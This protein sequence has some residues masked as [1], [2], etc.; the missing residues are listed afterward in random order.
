VHIIRLGD[1]FLKFATTVELYKLYPEKHE[2]ALTSLRNRVICNDYQMLKCRQL[3]ISKYLRALP[4]ISGR[5]VLNFEPP[6]RGGDAT[7]L[8]TLWNDMVVIPLEVAGA[9]RNLLKNRQ[10]FTRRGS[11]QSFLTRVKPKCLADMVEALIGVYYL[12]G[13]DLAGNMAIKALGCWPELQ[14]IKRATVDDSQVPVMT[15]TQVQEAALRKAMLELVVPEDYPPFLAKIALRRIDL[16][17]SSDHEENADLDEDGVSASTVDGLYRILGYRFVDMDILTEA[18]THCSVQYKH[19]N[20]RLEFLGDAVLDF[21]AVALLYN[22]QPSATQ[23]EL[24][25]QKSTACNNHNLGCKAIELG[26]QRY[27]R[28]MSG[29]LLNEFRD[30]QLYLDMAVEEAAATG[31]EII[32]LDMDFVDKSC[33]KAMA[34][35]L[36]ALFGALYLDSHGSLDAVQAVIRHI[37]LLPQLSED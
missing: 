7:G 31:G 17:K 1:S 2:G 20:Q 22:K 24:S 25:T 26:L 10:T 14:R 5:Q 3:G 23:G 18:L 32:K 29:Q 36:E 35:A 30:I 11:R 13:G 34:D 28:V 9:K 4:V 15:L 37:N 16:P 8:H 19:S 21:G 12:H 33:I 27:L 6:G